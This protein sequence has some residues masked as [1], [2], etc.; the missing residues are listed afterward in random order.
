M[1]KR[2][3][4]IL[5]SIAM[6][7]GDFAAPLTAFAADNAVIEASTDI[8]FSDDD[9]SL[10]EI[11]VSEEDIV[12]GDETDEDAIEEDDT[13]E[14][15]DEEDPVA[16]EAPDDGDYND[17]PT[18]WATFTNHVRKSADT[19]PINDIMLYLSPDGTALNGKIDKKSSPA[20]SGQKFKLLIVGRNGKTY[21]HVIDNDTWGSILDAKVYYS[22]DSGWSSTKVPFSDYQNYI[23]EVVIRNIS[24]FTAGEAFSQWHNLETVIFDDDCGGSSKTAGANNKTSTW[25]PS[26]FARCENLTSVLYSDSLTE[27]PEA[28][29]MDCENLKNVY[30]A[31]GTNAPY[32][33][34]AY[35][36]HINKV[37][38]TIQV[39]AFSGC[40]SLSNLE[41]PNTVREICSRAFEGCD[42]LKEV[43]FTSTRYIGDRA[44]FSS[45]ITKVELS[46]DL[47]VRSETFA[48]CK[49][50]TSVSLGA[51][52]LIDYNAFINCTSLTKL[53]LGN[54][55]KI[56]VSAFEGCTGLTELNLSKVAA[57]CERA[58]YGC[59]GL[60]SINL[61]SCTEV[62]KS[63]FEGCSGLTT[64]NLSNVEKIGEKAF[65]KI[66]ANTI[67]FPTSVTSLGKGSFTDGQL[68]TVNYPGTSS[69]WKKK[70]WGKDITTQKLYFGNAKIVCAGDGITIDPT[71]PDKP[72]PTPKPDPDK[73]T[74]TPTPG[75]GGP[76]PT[77][78]EPNAVYHTVTFTYSGSTV[79]TEKVIDGGTVTQIPEVTRENCTFIGW[80]TTSHL[81]WNVSSP[82]FSD[83][84]V[85]AKF[86]NN[87]TGAIEPK[88]SGDEDTDDGDE[89][90]DDLDDPDIK[91]ARNVYI[92]KGQKIRL[93]GCT[94]MST[95]SK[96][97][98]CSKLKG[99][100][101][102]LTAKKNGTC[103][104]TIT[105]T[106][107]TTLTH[108]FYVETPKLSDK[109]ITIGLGQSAKIYTSIGA[110]T[111]HYK[112]YWST[113]NPDV[114][115]VE[116][117]II[118]GIGAGSAKIYA[119]ICGKQYQ[120]SVKVKNVISPT[121]WADKIRLE[122]LQKATIKAD[123]FK[124]KNAVWTI[125]NPAVVTINK[126][127]ITAI[128][129]GTANI[130]GQDSN[131]MIISF[132]VSVMPP[133]PRILHLNIGKSK[134]PKLYQVK[135]NKAAW[136]TS[137]AEVASVVAG[138]ITGHKPGVALITATY[139]GFIYRVYV[140]VENPTLTPTDKLFMNGKKYAMSLSPSTNSVIT[141]STV[142]QTIYW[143]SS[144]PEIARVNQ[145]GMVLPLSAGKTKLT[146]KINGKT[147]SVVVNV[148][149]SAAGGGKASAKA[150]IDG[151]F[152]EYEDNID[153]TQ[154]CIDPDNI[155][156][157]P[158]V[159]E[160]YTDSTETDG[161]DEENL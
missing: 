147:I 115:Y 65:N 22:N 120:C 93:K 39:S 127:K 48:E 16:D 14:G 156:D 43:D 124:A 114:A 161:Y 117:G 122:P 140:Y 58:F 105:N 142:Y 126:G 47:N 71:K 62:E 151:L 42:S 144:K 52:E 37:L 46:T 107:G 134:T 116:D 36:P 130:K 51:T 158:V 148:F 79:Y 50:L 135:A 139:N 154:Y 128:A 25:G 4:P 75:P 74:P 15:V 149:E 29:F 82:V 129:C 49:S 86:Q 28:V 119:N 19:H 108:M 100:Y 63:A 3:L 76:T 103:M 6:A 69:D 97:V 9:D 66:G 11:P 137:N 150:D 78:Y 159:S 80:Y 59:S 131:G 20:D 70:D 141:S 68:L 125:D 83:I 7:F 12:S 89:P 61:S 104:V 57:V 112:M 2:L 40:R 91:D 109:K 32:T 123:G 5:L 160:E 64:L 145:F 106:A 95:D 45:G 23:T 92:V 27:F 18:G 17:K 85:S 101:T 153:Y 77:P 84:K 99:G 10:P 56:E 96:V 38:T 157:L 26:M 121:S 88:E 81:M 146:A 33:N 13:A 155:T 102:T 111:D 110:W 132:T 118:H 138:K 73:P 54:T 152:Y 60:N 8:V 143:K 31:D 67:T 24:S 44:F 113:S 1:K 30:N 55:L 34:T 90:Y 136:T 98:K 133:T 53:S 72:T 94:A 41:M 87:T 21:N 35:T